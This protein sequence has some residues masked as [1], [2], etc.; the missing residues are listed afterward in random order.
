MWSTADV[1]RVVAAMQAA[2]LAGVCWRDHR[3][4]P[5]ARASLALLAG[6]FAHMVGPLLADRGGSEPLVHALA[7]VSASIPFAFWLLARV[8]FD[9]EP[10]LRGVHF[11]LLAALL[12]ARHA[13]WLVATGRLVAGEGARLAWGILP[14]LFGVAFVVHALVNVYVGT[15][16]DL[17]LARLRLR[18]GV[19]GVVGTYVLIELL[20]EAL[21]VGRP[22]RGS[23]DLHAAASCVLLVGVSFVALR[24]HPEI[25]RPARVPAETPLALDPALVERLRGLIEAERVFQQEGLTVAGLAQRLGTQEHRVRQL[26]NAQLGFKNFNAFLHHYR[27]REAQ[28]ALA[29]PAR[30]HRS[31]SEIAFEVG[32]ASLGP[33][34]RAFKELTGVTPTEFRASLEARGLADSGIGQLSP[35]KQGDG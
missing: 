24:L 23:E 1:L 8:H 2:L 29:D 27:V 6:S 18:Y 28:R 9:D 34:N 22:V 35:G 19:L 21:F 26:I 11:A 30:R 4:D 20:A 14:R 31:V 13:G 10:R 3:G 17:V 12:A 16:S 5:S 25:L 33:F 32:Y 15:R 7:I